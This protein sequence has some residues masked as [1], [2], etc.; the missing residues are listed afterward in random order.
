MPST[1]TWLD[2]SERERRKMLDVIHLFDEKGTRDELG[3]GAVRDSF[4]DLF[5][6]GTTTIQTR[7][8]YFLFVPW[9]HLD[10]ERR[11]IPSSQ[12]AAQAR[13]QEVVLIDAL[14]KSDDKEG[15]IGID[16][17]AS[18]KRLPSNV[19]W[20]GMGAW[21]I[22]MFPGSQD[23]YNRSI[24]AFYVSTLRNLRTDDGDTADGHVA[25]NW[26]AA[27]P[28]MSKDFPGIATFSLTNEEAQYLRERI[29]SRVPHSLLAFLVGRGILT[30]PVEFP[31]EHSQYGDFPLHIKEQ[32][33]HARNFSEAIH[34]AALL[35]NLMLA[36]KAAA[37][38]LTEDYRNQL[39]EW[40][41]RTNERKT[42]F[43]SWD[44]QKFWS[45]VESSGQRVAH[46]TKLFINSWLDIAINSAKGETITDKDQ[47]R[48]LI[49]ERERALKNNL[50][51]LDNQRALELW[52]GAAGSAQLNYR[53]P[54]T[55]RIVSDI[56]KGLAKEVADA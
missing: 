7:A 28:P 32:L 14:A 15:T 40:A 30:E 49:H 34:G 38:E 35:Y 17:R 52:T 43:I 26:H 4:A 18:L 10:L 19:Y 51:R 46:P 6:P 39:E 44:R 31:W 50:A 1:F 54:V 8:K 16:A 20:Q 12:F 56:L 55:Q 5:F 22:R 24:D 53:W 48:R 45:I 41:V 37:V 13:W 11:K 27:I 29:W 25:R 9:I 42:I 3:I 36:E 2:Y 23:H 33:E 21:G 47:V